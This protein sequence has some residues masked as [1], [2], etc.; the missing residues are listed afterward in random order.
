MKL[1][2]VLLCLCQSAHS[3]T[4]KIRLHQNRPVRRAQRETAPVWR[5]ST[6]KDSTEEPSPTSLTGRGRALSET[7]KSVPV[8]IVGMMGSGKSTTGKLFAQ[9]LGDYA[10]VDTD[11]VLEK[12]AGAKIG[13]IFESVGEAEFRKMESSVLQGVQAYVRL[14]VSTGG[15]AV[16]TE[17]NWGVLQAGVVLFL[18]VPPEILAKRLDADTN[19]DNRPLLSGDE[20]TLDKVT[21]ILGDRRAKYEQADVT[22]AVDGTEAQD[23]LVIKMIDA[24]EAFIEANPP[25]WKVWKEK[26]TLPAAE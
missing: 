22:V 1:I 25:K 13:E 12:A 17:S 5:H 10:F 24:L 7:L 26:A 2:I 16:V 23:D 8:Y 21:A 3:W 11:E 15:G 19:S 20:T 9:T 14:V 6:L 4:S 18:D